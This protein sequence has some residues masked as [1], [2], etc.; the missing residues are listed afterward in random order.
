MS[1][2]LTDNYS[3]QLE[4]WQFMVYVFFFWGGGGGLVQAVVLTSALHQTVCQDVVV[5]TYIDCFVSAR[6]GYIFTVL[7]SQ[8]RS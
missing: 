4:L 1:Q 6:Q 3:S 5:C 7:K 2:I 8:A